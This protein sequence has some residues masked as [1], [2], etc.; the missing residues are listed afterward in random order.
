MKDRIMA[1]KTTTLGVVGG[2]ATI[3]T[4]TL[5][6]QYSLTDY[7]TWLPGLLIV[8]AGMLMKGDKPKE[9]KA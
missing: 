1:W 4:S 5:N 9:T 7:K 6:C 2:V 3:L 8:V